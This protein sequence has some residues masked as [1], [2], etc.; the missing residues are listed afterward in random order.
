MGVAHDSLFLGHLGVRKTKDRIQTNLFWPGLH[1]DVTSFCRSCDVCQK[2]F[3][4]SSVPRAPLE[5]MPLIDPA[6]KRVAVDPVRVQVH[7]DFSGLRDKIP[8]S[9]SAEEHRYRDGS[10]S[11]V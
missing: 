4:R 8:K 11:V 10:R 5:D 9:C 7:P 3:A 6:F 2:T 1:E